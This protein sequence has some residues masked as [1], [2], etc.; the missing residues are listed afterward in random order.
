MRGADL[1]A[2]DLRGA[3][4]LDFAAALTAVDFAFALPALAAFLAPAD[5]AAF[6]GAGLGDRFGVEFTAS[7]L[8]GALGVTALPG[9]LELRWA[10]LVFAV[11]AAFVLAWS[12][13]FVFF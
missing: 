11:L 6:L 2:A 12:A 1:R 7:A 3:A 8:S 5:A 4:L 9:V 10:P 13:F